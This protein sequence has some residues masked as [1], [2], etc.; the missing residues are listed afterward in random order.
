MFI[1]ESPVIG[2]YIKKQGSIKI[3]LYKTQIGNKEYNHLTKK[4]VN[5]G[6]Q[7]K[8]PDIQKISNT[9]FDIFTDA[10]KK[11]SAQ[12]WREDEIKEEKIIDAREKRLENVLGKEVQL[13]MNP[14]ILDN[15]P[16]DVNIFDDVES[17]KKEVD[18]IKG[19]ITKDKKGN[20]K[21]IKKN[22]KMDIDVSTSY[23]KRKL[24]EFN[25]EVKKKVKVDS[26]VAGEKRKNA[27]TP[28]KLSK[29]LKADKSIAGTKRTQKEQGR[30]NQ[31]RPKTVKTDEFGFEKTRPVATKRK[32]TKLENPKKKVQKTKDPKETRIAGGKTL[33][34]KKRVN[35]KE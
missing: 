6:S 13:L 34:R 16:Y 23:V 8:L 4:S 24:D 1:T 9:P 21:P 14:N 3:P 19:K 35:Y 2:S 5:Y 33:R 20:F 32:G 12:K 17:M 29:K 31:K 25:N 26:S 7:T 10:P 28:L 27:D 22:D 18:K 11:S 30:F 15:S